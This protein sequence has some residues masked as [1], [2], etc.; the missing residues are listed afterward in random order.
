MTPRFCCRHYAAYLED[1]TCFDNSKNRGQPLYFIY[2]ASQVI[3]GI[4]MVLPILSRGEKARIVIP[5]EVT[6]T[7]KL[8][9]ICC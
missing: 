2:G 5:A 1:G 3:P 4:E 7:A 8:P 6:N 9:F